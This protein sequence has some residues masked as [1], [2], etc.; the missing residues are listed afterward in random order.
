MAGAQ[1][2]FSIRSRSRYP[3]LTEIAAKINKHIFKRLCVF[4]SVIGFDGS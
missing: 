2:L 3:E 4:S 1:T